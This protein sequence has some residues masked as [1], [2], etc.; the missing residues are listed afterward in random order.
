[1]EITYLDKKEFTKEQLER[2]FLSVEWE[3]GNF[4]DL[5]V[6]AMKGYGSVFSAWNQETLI[7]LAAT[8]DDG[9]MTAYTHYLLV[10]P[11]YQGYHIGKELMTMVK[12]YYKDYNKLMLIAAEGK[13]GFY[14]KCGYEPN[15][16][17]TAMSLKIFNK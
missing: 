3:S 9:I 15:E 1:M 7:G 13:S 4:P 16:G 2:L 8:M 17:A 6:E 14:H 5:L 11:M 12:E 10:D